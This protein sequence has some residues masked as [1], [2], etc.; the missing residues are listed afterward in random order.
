MHD[1]Y[2]DIFQVKLRIKGESFTLS[3]MFPERQTRV[4]GSSRFQF[5]VS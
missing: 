4:S 2:T 1:L 3:V 5:A